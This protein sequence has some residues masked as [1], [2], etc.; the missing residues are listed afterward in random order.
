MADV[1]FL[2][3]PRLLGIA[4]IGWS[5]AAGRSWSEYRRR[6]GAHGGRLEALGVGYHRSPDV[7]WR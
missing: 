6:L 4:E 1:E 5:R 3:F 7:P 2:L